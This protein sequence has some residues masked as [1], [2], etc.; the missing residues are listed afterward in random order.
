VFAALGIQHVMRMRHIVNFLVK[1]DRVAA[2]LA[3]FVQLFMS[4]MFI[5]PCIIVISEV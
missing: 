3:S 4:L 2:G 5:V 1:Y